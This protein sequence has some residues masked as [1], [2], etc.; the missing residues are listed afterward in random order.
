MP[1]GSGPAAPKTFHL[2]GSVAYFARHG[3]EAFT[4]ALLSHDQRFRPNSVQ[5]EAFLEPVRELSV[6]SAADPYR[7]RTREILF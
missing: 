3:T 4:P 2:Y 1:R 6:L 7:L 5:F